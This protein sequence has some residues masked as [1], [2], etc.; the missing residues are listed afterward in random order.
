MLILE[1][2]RNIAMR[3]WGL[4]AV[5]LVVL[6]GALAAWPISTSTAVPYLQR[7]YENS[8][9]MKFVPIPPGQFV[10]GSPEDEDGRDTDESQHSVTLTKGFYM[11]IV[12]VT[13]A[14]WVMVMETDPSH[15]QRD[16]LPVENVSWYDA[17]AFCQKLSHLE[18]RRYRLPTEAEWEYACRAGTTTE[19]Y[20][21]AG[22]DALASI[23]W[24]SDN[25]GGHTRSVGGKL[26]NAWGLYD[27][28]GNVWQWCWDYYG[29]YPDGAVVN[30]TGPD[31]AKH[32]VCR[33][34][35]W[36]ASASECRCATRNDRRPD[37]HYPVV[38]F[39]VVLDIN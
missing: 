21:G 2:F 29:D 23:A 17:E 1:R 28:E 39:R 6:L 34:G 7:T 24:D 38:G 14:Q 18:G 3:R 4:A 35:S 33:G 30:P 11:A 25:S 10:M 19:F 32:K 26:P 31:M 15:W 36:G 20:S 13:Q 22:N 12:P 9:G 5:G 37:G 8:V 27:M 16:D